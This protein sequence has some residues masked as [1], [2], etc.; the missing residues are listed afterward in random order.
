M[1]LVNLTWIL[2]LNIIDKVYIIGGN[3]SKDSTT[4]SNCQHNRSEN[5][6]KKEKQKFF[7]LMK[8]G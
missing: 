7:C 5:G 2:D 1:N 8:V 6:L 4:V 3:G